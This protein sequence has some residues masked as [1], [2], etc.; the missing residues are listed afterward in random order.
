MRLDVFFWALH[1]ATPYPRWGGGGGG[2]GGGGR[3]VP[4]R[5]PNGKIFFPFMQFFWGNLKKNCMLAP[6]PKGWHPS[7]ENTGYAPAYSP[8]LSK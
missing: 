6:P 3:R 8:I 2:G 4:A 7:Y 5:A 1:L